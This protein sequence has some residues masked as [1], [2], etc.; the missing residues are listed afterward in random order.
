M[1]KVY[2]ETTIP[3]YLTGKLSR[4]IVIAAQQQVTREWWEDSQSK[5]SLYISEAVLDE[6]QYGDT[7]AARKRTDIVKQLP[8]LRITDEVVHLAGCYFKILGIPE[9]SILDTIHLAVAVAYELDYL[10]TWN[11]KHLAHG[12]I[13]SKV[14]KYNMLNGLFEPMIVTPYELLRRD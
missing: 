1:E 7:E 11:C 3:S 4:D 14:H 9:K 5:Y 10:L 8:I 2:I 12:E 13:R 6:C